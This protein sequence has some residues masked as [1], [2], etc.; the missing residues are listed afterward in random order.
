MYCNNNDG[1]TAVNC[2]SV[3][4]PGRVLALAWIMDIVVYTLLRGKKQGRL[5]QGQRQV[6][7]RQ[8]VVGAVARRLKTTRDEDGATTE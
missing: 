4:A 6:W 3:H 5:S 8:T 1:R 7:T 2:Q